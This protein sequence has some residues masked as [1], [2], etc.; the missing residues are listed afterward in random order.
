MPLFIFILGSF[1]SILV[2]IFDKDVEQGIVLFVATIICSLI[3]LAIRVSDK[4]QE[5]QTYESE[6]RLRELT[7]KIMT[8]KYDDEDR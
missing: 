2:M 8:N 1:F 5:R 7:E 6:Q 3:G 4:E